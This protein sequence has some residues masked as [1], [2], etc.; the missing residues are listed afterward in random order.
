MEEP[1]L[2]AGLDKF[3]FMLPKPYLN[4]PALWAQVMEPTRS[5][6]VGLRLISGMHQAIAALAGAGNYVVADHVLIDSRWLADA[7]T[8]FAQRKAYF[9]GVHCPLEVVEQRERDR[10]DRTLGQAR[11]QYELVHAHGEYDFTVN[12]AEATPEECARQIQAFLSGDPEP[13][14]FRQ[15]TEQGR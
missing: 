15:L 13:R 6:P 3:L 14:A 5:G 12:T 4:Q 11:Q 10:G 1:Y 7:S 8:V 9:I 2:D